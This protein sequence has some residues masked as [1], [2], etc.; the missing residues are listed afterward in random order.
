[1]DKSVLI[2]GSRGMLA[3]DISKVW[4]EAGYTV[5]ELPHESL[6]ITRPDQVSLAMD[7][8]K[9]NIVINTPGISVDVCETD[10]RA[11]YRIHTWAAQN[12]A[13]NCRRIGAV[14]VYISTCGLFGDDIKFYSEYDPVEIKTKY[15]RSKY[16]GEKVSSIQCEE[17]FVIRPGWLFGGQISHS[18]NFVYQRYLEAVDKHTLISAADKYGSPTYTMDLSKKLLEVVES[19]QYGL[20]HITNTGQASRYEYVQFIIDCLGIDATVD[21]VDSSFFQRSAPVPDCEMLENLNIQFLGIDLMSDW[22]DAIDRYVWQLKRQ[23]LTL[24]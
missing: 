19:E 9:P 20:Y 3:S 23:G 17:L 12:I 16:L 22:Q 1:M 11:G 18:R 6:D 7:G 15:A 24:S 14:C 8:I 10:P 2:T 21:P 5:T 4:T 13:T